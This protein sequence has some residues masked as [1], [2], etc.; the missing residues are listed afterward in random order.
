V[1][2]NL[3]ALRVLRACQAQDRPATDAEQRVLAR[4][5]GWGAVPAVFDDTH[6]E[7]ALAREAL[8]ALLNGDEYAAAARNT[9]NAHYTDPALVSAIWS[10]LGELGFTA[11]RVLEPGCGSG[12]FIG[13]APPGADTVGVELDPV[14]AGITGLLYPRAQVLAESFADTR[15]PEA[16]FDLVVGN[17][18]F[19]K[20]SLNDPRHNRAGHSIHNHF[21]I[22]S[23]H[24]VA[25][26]GLVALIT[27]RYTLDA[28]NPAA[29]REIAALADLVGAI[30]LPSSAHQR[31]AGTTVVT[32]LLVLRRR[33]DGF[34]PHGDSGW[35]R[36]DLVTA[37]ALAGGTATGA[38]ATGQSGA[39]PATDD[40]V[41]INAYFLAHPQMVC[42]QLGIGR[43]MF[44][45]TELTVTA[46]RPA[47]E[48]LTEAL[49]RLVTHAHAA[50]LTH[51]PTA[52]TPRRAALVGRAANLAEGHIARTDDGFTQVEDG[53]L[54]PF[55]V[56]GTQRDELAALLGLRDSAVALLTAE[57]ASMDDSAD[58]TDLRAQLNQRYDRYAARWGPINRFGWKRSGRVN[59]ATGQPSMARIT[60][61]QG[62]FRGDP[63][64]PVVYALE[65][66]DPSTGHA[67]KAAILTRRVVA[68]RAPRLGADTP[69]DALAIC[70]DTHGRVDL[71]DIARLLGTTAADARAQLGALVFDDPPSA[72]VPAI[73]ST[74]DTD[75]GTD[76][77]A[78][79]T[80]HIAAPD[81]PARLIPAAE[82][83]S[84]NVREKLAA[85]VA[86]AA[87]DDRFGANVTALRPVV[88]ADIAPEDIH[89]A[90]GVPWIGQPH[91]QQFLRETF[92]D[93]SL[94]A[95]HAHGVNWIVTGREVGVAATSTWGTP[96]MP[97][98]NLAQTLLRQQPV[99]VHDEIEHTLA[100]GTETTRRVLNPA[101]T[102][103]AQAKAEELA[104]RFSEWVWQDSARA[105]ELARSYNAAF[106]SLV[107]RNYDDV[108]L[109]LPGLAKDFT[110]RPH[111]VAAVARM[112]AEPAVGL[113]H[114]VGAGKTAEM[115]MGV[116]ELRRLGLVS[117]PAIVI[118]NHMIEQLTREFAQLYPRARLLAIS[119]DDLTR[120]KRRRF[121]ARIAT[122][123]WDAVILTSGAFERIPMSSKAQ[124]DYLTAQQDHL[125]AAIAR[126]E[127]S[128]ER[129]RSLKRMQRTLLAAEER[130]KARLERDY[131]PA[132]T[133]QATGID[134][135]T[136]DEAHRYKNL[137]TPSNISGAA[138]EGST[139]ASDLDMKLHYLRGRRPDGRVG[140]F[141]TATP[142]ANSVTEAHVM[143]RYLRPD[144]LAAANVSDFD[145]WAAVFGQTVSEIELSVS[146]SNFRAKQRFAKFHNLPELLRLWW[147]PG[148][149]KIAEDLNLPRPE[150]VARHDGRR[151]P[152]T[153]LIPRSVELGEFIDELGLRAERIAAGAADRDEDNIL[154]ISRE[155]RAAA[156]DLRLVGRT[157]S[158][159]DTKLDIAAAKIAAIW[160][161]H[162]EDRF[163]NPDGTPH[164]TPG[165]LQIVFCDQGTPKPAGDNE[166]WS[167]YGE[168]KRQLVAH[169]VPDRQVQFVQSTRNDREKAELF[170]AC[171][172]GRIS[173]LIGSTE[174]M[175]VGTN[176]QT[177]AV[178]LH[179]LD[180]PWR[181]AD[182]AQR[183]GRILRQ[184]CQ[185]P[186][187]S[188]YRYVTENSF[189][190][191]SWQTVARKAG[192]IGQVMRG[193]LD[194]REIEDLGDT[195]LSYSEVKA[196]AAGNPLL[197]D[198]ARA[199]AEL[200]RL[201]RLERS[202]TASRTRLRQ[203]IER[204]QDTITHAGT[205]V[206]ALTSAIERRID[207]RADAFAA[208]VDGLRYTDRAEAGL[209]L[210]EWLCGAINSAGAA[211]LAL[212]DVARLGG[213]TVDATVWCRPDQGWQLA[214]RGVDGAVLSGSVKSL[215]EMAPASLIQRLENQ[216]GRFERYLDIARDRIATSTEEIDR[217]GGQLERGFAHTEALAAARQA[218]AE[219]NHTLAELA[220][221]AQPAADIPPGNPS[222]D[223]PREAL[224]AA[225]AGPATT[226]A[227]ENTTAATGIET[228]PRTDITSGR[229]A[230]GPRPGAAPQ[231]SHR[232]PQAPVRPSGANPG[233]GPAQRPGRGR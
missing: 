89:V 211:R 158:G 140:C 85:A 20:V 214:V 205:E 213:H 78:E 189:D 207:T 141:A 27:S 197:L 106:N 26:G 37:T 224:G 103:A 217:A 178:A 54:R 180:C 31:T 195:T 160:R 40:T 38:R 82:Y 145:S 171:R 109:S 146:G 169:G 33:E 199:D 67:D 22:K 167:A 18:P 120:D 64:S 9:L 47:H 72:P 25:P 14:T 157:A 135:I 71:E 175:G 190:A 86:A 117:K 198:K 34:E 150:L 179:H 138:I 66:F 77:D 4:W 148:D 92:A 70:L 102:A 212:P 126:Q 201:E 65:E 161:E 164:P 39:R 51:R 177:R 17:V 93:P 74:A 155:G 12:T 131:D 46:Q 79:R 104:Q 24:L 53:Q 124:A 222:D 232:P 119:G 114:E 19:A 184:G 49:D 206:A 6:S 83:L 172:T 123:D 50:E 69:A 16:A 143:L 63:H 55:P 129:S 220:T 219:I 125:R 136:I 204:H 23:L 5:S 35:E 36:T 108:E 75:R 170:Q 44:S 168:L 29:R 115:A 121:V 112:I 88:P 159:G 233:C 221:P 200:V 73:G 91:V 127:A 137:H 133:F 196:L 116:M 187:V 181:P 60:P 11:G 2:A 174:T 191:Y 218:C 61:G 8:A 107:L 209:Q 68:P 94:T 81:E 176:V 225:A 230:V 96:D 7:F 165:G 30:R 229:P 231:P 208:T 56:P 41:R 154:N 57:A 21:I 10:A 203:L 228:R 80:S 173:V 122:G 183:D 130:A 90:L 101:K 45:A 147:V 76:F 15:A 105:E 87:V 113:W 97:A 223:P 216:L 226:T 139:R 134:Y 58:I 100:D 13:L 182:L 62:G 1:Q 149:V 42:G 32:D 185:Y 132:V 59:P 95:E 193:R 152:V 128:G 210:R 111:Q 3:E 166:Q 28:A 118:P 194:V 162:R 98:P 142:I 52:A 202:H 215:G 186:E 192:F 153:V 43:G 144:L 48:L 163:T 156:L 188:I 110:P 151:E 84:G 227:S 99:L